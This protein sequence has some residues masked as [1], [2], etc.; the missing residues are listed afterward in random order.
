MIEWGTW[1]AAAID[2]VVAAV[3]AANSII[4][5]ND[6]VDANDDTT[7]LGLGLVTTSVV[8]V[9]VI[10]PVVVVVIVVVETFPTSTGRRRWRR[11]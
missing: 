9:V 3:T 7:A 2:G 10:L 1:D 6:A 11:L 4:M 5:T 8:G